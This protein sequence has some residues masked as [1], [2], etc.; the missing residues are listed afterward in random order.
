M[1][2]GFDAS[3]LNSDA[4]WV[5]FDEKFQSEDIGISSLYTI[6]IPSRLVGFD[7]YDDEN[8]ALFSQ[9]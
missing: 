1:R 5:N 9:P 7:P 8:R 3:R 2:C 6:S 4:M